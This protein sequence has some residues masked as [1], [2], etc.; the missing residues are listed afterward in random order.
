MGLG[1]AVS[2]TWIGMW[3]NAKLVFATGHYL[4]P[5]RSRNDNK[6]RVKYARMVANGNTDI[7]ECLSDLVFANVVEKVIVVV[8]LAPENSNNSRYYDATSAT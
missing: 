4:N 3:T 1:N 8:V 7:L 5:I 6:L 2:I